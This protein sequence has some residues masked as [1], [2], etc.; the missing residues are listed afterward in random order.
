[1]RIS[2]PQLMFLGLFALVIVS[3]GSAF[4]AG[5][6]VPDSNVGQQSVPVTAEDVKPEACAAIYLTN[7][8]SGSGTLTGTAGNDLI[9]GSSAADLI[10]GLGGNDCIV[11]SGG[12]DSLTGNEGNDVCLSGI[13]NDIFTDCE[14]EIQ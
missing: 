5:L 7:I 8:V 3:V 14:T 1:M 13:G 11:G 9:I 4:A 10:D 2:F 6:S 12:D